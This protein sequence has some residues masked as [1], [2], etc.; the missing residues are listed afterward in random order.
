MTLVRLMGFNVIFITSPLYPSNVKALQA[1]TLCS[2]MRC[3]NPCWLL[4]PLPIE[5]LTLELERHF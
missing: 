2:T 5:R 3:T 4:L 1:M